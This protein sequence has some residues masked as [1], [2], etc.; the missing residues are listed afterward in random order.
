MAWS[1][2]SIRST[3]SGV[4]VTSKRESALIR[5]RAHAAVAGSPRPFPIQFDAAR[6]RLPVRRC[7]PT[8]CEGIDDGDFEF[9]NM[10]MASARVDT[11]DQ[12]LA[13]I[14]EVVTTSIC[15][16]CLFLLLVA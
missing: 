4:V 1:A 11:I 15:T 5:D 2:A 10:D 7:G 12:A 6:R 13:V 9:V 14:R 8:I 16:C 3:R